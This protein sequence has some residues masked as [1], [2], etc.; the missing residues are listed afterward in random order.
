[1]KSAKRTLD[2][3]EAFAAARRPLNITEL[4]GVLKVPVS[5]CFGLVSALAGQGYLQPA[6]DKKAFYPTRKMLRCVEIIAAHEPI[7]A[8]LL[9]ALR[10]LRDDSRET[11]ILGKPQAGWRGV[12]YL[13]VL[14]GP[15]NIRYSAAVGDIKPLHSSSIG[16]ALL[17]SLEAPRLEAVLAKLRLERVTRNTI[18]TKAKLK[19]D[20]E[21]GLRRGYQMTAGENVTDVAAV[22]AP[23][24][25]DDGLYA[26]AIAAPLPRMESQLRRLTGL[27]AEALSDLGQNQGGFT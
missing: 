3:F 18:T 25:V 9:P 5:S 4:S 20:I 27:L 19:A 7:A 14:E 21:S 12:V 24:R 13:E 22:A 26:V 6:G 17:S 2:L 10:R 11:V 8:R 23:F 1:M 15:Q 16:K